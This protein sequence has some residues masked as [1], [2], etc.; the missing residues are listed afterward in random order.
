[1]NVDAA[2]LEARDICRHHAK[3]FYLASHFLPREKRY[4]AY[5][6]Y[7]FCRLLDDAADEQPSI[8]SVARFEQLLDRIYSGTDPATEAGAM[9]AFARTVRDCDIPQQHFLD[10]ARGCRMDFTITRYDTWPALEHYC[11][12]VAGVVG[13]IMCRVFGLRDESALARAVQ[14][15]NAMQLTNILRDV[16][17][18]HARG[19]VYL[20]REDLDRFGVS[21]ADL[22]SPS[23]TDALKQL[24]R[25]EIVR[26]RSLYHEAS[27]GLS[28]LPDDGS[29]LT[30]CVMA[31][32]YAGILG[33]IERQSHDVLVARA[34]TNK[35]QKL[36]R[37]LK[38]RRLARWHEGQPMPDVW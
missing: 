20:P 18:D 24:V 9:Q 38:A 11:Y 17:E 10:L 5:A 35:L 13:L 31:V 12:H 25:F 37:V 16:R 32:V 28:K 27:L 30:A 2:Y 8:E 36:A 22:G 34:H 15:G 6:V 29:R 23:S 3:S 19:R 26:A 7:A 21:E 1:M 4:H 33:A 14:M